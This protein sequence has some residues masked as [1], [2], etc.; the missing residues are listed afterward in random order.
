MNDGFFGLNVAVRGLYTAQRGLDV[1][2]HNLNNVNTP[3][4]S[5]QQAVQVASTPMC[6]FDGTGMVG[7]GSDVIA[8]KRIRDGYLDSKFWS[9]NNPYGEWNTKKTLLS[10]IETTFNE[11]SDSGF[12]TTMDDFYSSMQELAK[13][14]S[15][16]ADRA[17]VREKG[18]TLAKYFNSI[19]THF[20]KL[21]ADA[22]NEVNTKVEEIN[23]IGTQIQQLNRQIYTAELDGNSAND[24][25][26]S[27]TLLTDKLSKLVNIDASEV[28]VGK[29]AGGRD[30]LHY[31]ITISGKAFIDHYNLSELQAKQRTAKVNP[32]DVDN[33]YDVQWKDGNSL[34]VKGGELK[35][36]L[37]VRDG[38]GGVNGGPIY[39]GIPHYIKKLNEFVQTFAMSF[40]EGF[41]NVKRDTNGNLISSAIID[42]TGHADG[43]GSSSLQG[44]PPSGIRFFTINGIG[45][46]PETTKVFLNGATGVAAIADQYKNMTAKNFCVSNDIMYDAKLVSTS[47]SAGDKGN[48][49][50]LNKLLNERHDPHMF[51]EGAPEDFMKSMITTLGI[52][53]EQAGTISSNQEAVVKQID[54]RRLSDSG[55]SIDEEMTN[56]VKF[57]H[58][59]NASAKMIATMTEIFD[60]LINK[61]G[62]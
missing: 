14:P 61:I 62:V 20:E 54:N 6:L 23:S 2:N 18:V 31:V 16:D 4:Y 17:I 8:V 26:D 60:T 33:L 35:G 34:E 48:I 24:L 10:D 13:D 29:L 9:E 40:N 55:V 19:D 53:S 38:N 45:Q 12:S 15:S 47:D 28:V 21:Q 43:Y 27:R 56:L 11:P 59:Y 22:N 37:D 39:N 3:G 30:D 44:D 51:A 32:E 46:N 52:D 36:Y 58:A 49:N 42:G 7:T 5:R 41:S 50:V 25:R 1:V 57:Q